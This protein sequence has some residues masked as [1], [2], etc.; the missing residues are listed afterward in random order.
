MPDRT[1]LPF[2]EIRSSSIQGLGVFAAID[3]QKA[4]RIIEYMGERI[5]PDEADTRYD[6]DAG[7]CTHVL[8]FIVD[9]DTVI[10]GGIGGNEAKYVNH[11][12][13]PNCEA[14]I[15]SGRVYIESLR[16]IPAGEEITFDYRLERAGEYEPEWEERY[17]C[18]C[19]S[20]R[21]R[22]TMLAESPARETEITGD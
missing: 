4:T 13:Q 2:I 20:R 3:I 6:D 15:D 12:C 16:E 18:K 11:S 10:D 9:E 1:N 5:S 17:A 19:G 7:S 8:L 21:C 22:G 14:V